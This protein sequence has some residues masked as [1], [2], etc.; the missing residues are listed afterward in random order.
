MI[1]KS[2]YFAIFR[3]A[4]VEALRNYKVL[5]GLSIFLIAC[6][7]IFAHLWKAVSSRLGVLHLT[8]EQL[9]WYIALN[10]WVLISI[11]GIESKIEEDLNSGRLAYLLPR[12]VSYLMATF[13]EAFGSL[14]ANLF[15]LGLI[16]FIF[17]WIYTG[18]F[19][20]SSYSFLAAIFLGLLATTVAV[21]Y[22][23]MIGVSAFWF[24]EIEPLNWIWEKLLFMLGGLMLPLA[25]YPKWLQWVAFLTPFPAIL[26]ARS[27][28]VIDFDVSHLFQVAASLIMWGV[29]G[30]M[31]LVFIYLRGLRILNMEGG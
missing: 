23:I 1:V 2:K 6:L 28:L 25:I 4:V 31:F 16:T 11:P 14:C 18:I 15:A 12:P 8:E 27:Q 21:I 5:I 3:L 19:L 17:T 30:G 7:V 10:E 22:Q 26:G 9:L 20:F 24:K 13:M 29:I